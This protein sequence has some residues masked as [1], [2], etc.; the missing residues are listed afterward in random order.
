VPMWKQV[1]D[2]DMRAKKGESTP[3]KDLAAGKTFNRP[4]G[5]F[6]GVTNVGA[7]PNWMGHHLALA[8]LYGFGR[9]A[10]D[11]NLSSRQ[12]ADEWTR[13]TFGHDPQ[14]VK[15]VVEIQLASWPAYENYTGPLGAGTLTD[16]LHGHYGP[17]IEASERNGWGQWHRADHEGIGMERTVGDGTGFIG[18]YSP[19]V[20]A[21][22]ESLK[23]CPDELLLFMHHVPYTYVLHSGK[24]V[25][26]HIYD[27]H[28]EGAAKAAQFVREWESLKSKIDEQRYNEVLDRLKYQAGSAEVWRDAVCDWFL[29]ESGIPD[30]KGRA[31]HFPGRIEAESMKLDGYQIVDV[32][33]W[34]TASGGKA[35]NCPAGTPQCTATL[36][37]E[38][39]PGWYDLRV[40]YFDQDNGVSNFSVYIAGQLVSRWKADDHFPTDKINGSSSTR[41]TIAGVAL[42]TGDKVVIEGIPNGGEGAPFDYIEILPLSGTDH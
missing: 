27:T 4:V 29:R 34:E 38:G 6:I 11:P 39:P 16:I 22:Y 5:A 36:T 2:F 42:R 33:P 19:P 21:M 12:I 24:T 18:Q 31:G 35:V 13:L 1:L 20:A 8:N 41:H 15:T 14:V 28:Y 10:W 37:Y 7:D 3:V 17:S 32:T 9:L 40:Q 25:I 26:Q 30:A 23:T